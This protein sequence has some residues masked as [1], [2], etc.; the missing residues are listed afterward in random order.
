MP[1]TLRQPKKDL[2]VKQQRV[3]HLGIL[4]S[5]VREKEDELE[6]HD[7]E[8]YTENWAGSRA[9][10]SCFDARHEIHEGGGGGQVSAGLT[11]CIS[12][13]LV[14]VLDDGCARL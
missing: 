11:S 12:V 3:G 7:G 4:K 6:L 8:G 1:R 14:I 13:D 9:G 5:E 2:L 10:T